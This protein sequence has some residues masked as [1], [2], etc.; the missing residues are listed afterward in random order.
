M[1]TLVAAT[2]DQPQVTI[3]RDYHSRN[4]LLATGPTELGVVDFQDALAGPVTYDLAS[5]LHDCYVRFE[6]DV[7]V[8]QQRGKVIGNGTGQGVLKV[9]DAEFGRARRQ[10]QVAGVIVPVNGDLRLVLGGCDERCHDGFEGL[11]RSAQ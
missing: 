8:V 2:Q 1:A 10:Q 4:L 6:P 9:D 5:L 3:H 7:A 11:A